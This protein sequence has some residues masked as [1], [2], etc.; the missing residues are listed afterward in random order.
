MECQKEKNEAQC[1]CTYQGC[2]RHGL[3]CQ[4]IA[5]HR[6]KNQMVACYFK[7]EV[8]RTYDRSMEN[9]LSQFR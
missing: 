2:P 3:C 9:F 6:S 8:E 5:Y 1:T 4:C 7:P